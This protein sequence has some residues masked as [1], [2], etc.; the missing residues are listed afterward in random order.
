MFRKLKKTYCIA[1][2]V[3][4]K[5]RVKAILF[6]AGLVCFYSGYLNDFDIQKT[7]S[8]IIQAVD[9]WKHTVGLPVH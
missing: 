4:G 1:C 3:I 2:V 9:T 6:V 7:A 8:D 5:K